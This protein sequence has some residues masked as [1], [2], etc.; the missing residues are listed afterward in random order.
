MQPYIL[1][2][3]LS[4]LAL[5]NPI[6]DHVA[7]YDRATTVVPGKVPETT[8]T[9]TACTA[10][11]AVAVPIS[12][13]E[14]AEAV[15]GCVG[16]VAADTNDTR[17]D[18]L[19][20]ICKPFTLIFA[21]GTGE[22]PNL[23]NLVGPPFVYALNA[24]FGASNVAVQGVNNY[25]AD[26]AGYCEGGSLTGSQDLASLIEQTMHQCP[27]TKLCVSGYS[28]G[29]Q[30]VHNAFELLASNTAATKFVNSVVLFGDPDNG[31][32]VGNVPAYKVSTDCHAG[33]NICQDGETI[34]EPHLSYCHDVGVEAAFAKKRSLASW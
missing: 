10:T 32:P 22:D 1:P 27:R 5:A 34:L 28:Q 20:G 23:G 13:T 18:I 33:D 9:G 3:L 11:N 7:I 30:V 21:R 31:L 17:N 6:A 26:D 4:T 24:T 2:L 14:I 8:P 19:D 15:A 16:V 12:S 25:A 29:A